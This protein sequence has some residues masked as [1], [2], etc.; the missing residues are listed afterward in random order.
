MSLSNVRMVM[1]CSADTSIYASLFNRVFEHKDENS[2]HMLVLSLLPSLRSL[3]TAHVH[4]SFKK[5]PLLL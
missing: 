5:S 2:I 3:L 4:F 1:L